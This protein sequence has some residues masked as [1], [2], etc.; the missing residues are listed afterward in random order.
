[1]K[2]FL[3]IFFNTIIFFLI[4]N[5]LITILWPIYSKLNRDKHNYKPEQVELFNMPDKELIILYKRNFI[6]KIK[7]I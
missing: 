1:M 3:V 7:A 4:I 2:K 5:F 6:W